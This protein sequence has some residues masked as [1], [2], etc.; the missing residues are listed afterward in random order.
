[1]H[2]DVDERLELTEEHASAHDDGPGTPLLRLGNGL[3]GLRE[4][5]EQLG[6]AVSFDS[7]SGFRVDAEVPAP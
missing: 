5:V 2:L 6:G 1:M 7:R 3:T 4:R